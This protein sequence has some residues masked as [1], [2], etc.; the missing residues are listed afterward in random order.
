M[1]IL[2][3]TNFKKLATNSRIFFNQLQIIREFVAKK[4]YTHSA[5]LCETK[6]YDK[7]ILLY[8]TLLNTDSIWTASGR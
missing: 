7:T 5:N 4:S 6:K 1:E 2:S 3:F 8:L